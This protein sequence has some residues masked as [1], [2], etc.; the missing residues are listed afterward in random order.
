MSDDIPISGDSEEFKIATRQQIHEA[1]NLN[2]LPDGEVI[3]DGTYTKEGW[4]QEESQAILGEPYH[5]QSGT[6]L[7][8][9]A[10]EAMYSATPMDLEHGQNVQPHVK[11]ISMTANPLRVM[12]AAAQLYR[13]DVVDDAKDIPR[14]IANDWVNDM[15]RTK[16]QAPLEFIDLHLL[17]GGVTRAFTHQLVRQRTAVYIQESMRFAVKG[18]AQWEVAMPPSISHLREDDPKRR[19]WDDTVA[20]MA[21]TYKTLIDAGIPAEDARGILPMNITTRVHYKTNLRALVDHSGMRLCSQAQHEW[22]VVWRRIIEAIANYGPLDERWQQMGILSLLGPVCYQ[23]GKCEFMAST[24]RHCSIRERVQ[25]HYANGDH[26][27]TW[28]DIDPMEPLM[29]G[30]ARHA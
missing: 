30:A 2:E 9:W 25:A 12:A 11:L 19:I 8:R 29:E 18:D 5:T 26:P 13:G 24:D 10:D 23:T 21:W 14:A 3:L 27:D 15:N 6:E 4:T 1:Y 28:S 22:K 16:L 7:A 20:R 17:I